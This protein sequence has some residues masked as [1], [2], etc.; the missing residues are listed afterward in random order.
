MVRCDKDYQPIW[1]NESDTETYV[2]LVEDEENGFVVVGFDS[3]GGIIKKYQK[4]DTND[5][6]LQWENKVGTKLAGIIRKENGNFV[7]VGNTTPSIKIGD[8]FISENAG[9][10]VECDTR[11]NIVNAVEVQC[12]NKE[13]FYECTGII[14]TLDGGFLVGGASRDDKCGFIK[15]Y[16]RNYKVIWEREAEGSRVCSIT[17]TADN[18]HYVMGGYFKGTI[19]IDGKVYTSKG[20]LD[21]IIIQY[22]KSGNIEWVK[23]YGGYG[24]DLVNYI[25]STK[26]NNLVAV[27]KIEG[28]ELEIEGEKLTT[29]AADGA[30]IEYNIDGEAVY[31]T[32]F[33]GTENNYATVIKETVD[34]KLLAGIYNN[35]ELTLEN[36]TTYNSNGIIIEVGENVI[37]PEV[38]DTKEVT[39]LNFKEEYYIYTKVEGGGGSVSGYISGE[40]TLYESVLYQGNS[41]KDIIAIPQEGYGVKSITVNG[42]EIKF[43][44]NLDGSVKL[45]KFENMSEDKH[46]VVRF[47]ANPAEVI[48]H[49]Y[50]DGTTTPV[51]MPDGSTAQ[52][53]HING[54]VDQAYTT[55]PKADLGKYELVASKMPAN[56]NGTMTA[57]NIEVIYY[58]QLKNAEVIVHHY[59]DGTTTSVPLPD[60]TSVEEE[61]ITGK[62]DDRYQT[63]ARTDISGYQVVDEKLPE[64]AQGSMREEPI[65]VIYYYKRI[66]VKITTEV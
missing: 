41:T 15:K 11:G 17:E 3:E 37:Q 55:N 6:S 64:N 28:D 24:T 27:I 5:Y 47:T 34:G 48:V 52:D 56:A 4:N 43:T 59:V 30:I 65:E 60:G 14:Q 66:P 50:I 1:L 39:F 26:G 51:P 54:E 2:E 40:E 29:N 12:E 20:G 22:D 25:T 8:I 18:M 44:R 33:S 49:H 63:N 36:G 46:V 23:T 35:G 58:Y 45:D 38:K 31:K 53:E 19:H 32:F 61:H 62:V 21:A 57:E 42:E 16:D 13:Y 7:A 9:I 10:I